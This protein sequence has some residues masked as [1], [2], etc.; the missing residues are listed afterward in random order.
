MGFQENLKHYRYKAG[1]ETAKQF[2]DD[3]GISYTTYFAYESKGR[4]PKYDLLI[5]IADLLC[6]SIDDL[7]GHTKKAI[8]EDERFEK[9]INEIISPI[10]DKIKLVDINKDTIYFILLSI[11][12]INPIVCH[13]DKKEFIKLI[14][15]KNNEY[16]QEKRQALQND[17]LKK[18][19]GYSY[20]AI[21]NKINELDKK[22][23]NLSR[24]E[25]NKC[26]DEIFKFLEVLHKEIH[27]SEQITQNDL[28]FFKDK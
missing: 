23:R 8:S 26:L 14:N 25:S 1:Y 12:S 9:F 27:L 5:K 16:E 2:A 18:I 15:K 21:D 4:E 20:I 13:I 28:I 17:L 3:L 19:K 24:E 11:K 10:S 7:L 22:R 6:V